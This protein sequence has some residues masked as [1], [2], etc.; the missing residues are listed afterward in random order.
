[1]PP[2]ELFQ[3]LIEKNGFIPLPIQFAHAAGVFS[4][5]RAHSD[6]FDRLLISQAR[7]EKLTLLS[8]DEVF[9]NYQLPGLVGPET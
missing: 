1:M 9:K 8:D 2:L 3:R 5:P 6:P 7:E 4:L